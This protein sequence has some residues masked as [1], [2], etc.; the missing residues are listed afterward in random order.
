MV[1]DEKLIN[2]V[3]GVSGSGPAYVF[4]LAEAMTKAGI[5]EGLDHGKR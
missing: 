2:A 3:T 5:N 1:L 4:A